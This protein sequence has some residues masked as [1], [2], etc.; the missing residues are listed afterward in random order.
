MPSPGVAGWLFL[1][2]PSPKRHFSVC[3]IF[4]YPSE[5]GPRGLPELGAALCVAISSDCI[6][7]EARGI[8][9]ALQI[10]I[11]GWRGVD[12]V[13]GKDRLILQSRRTTCTLAE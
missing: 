5:I 1:A 13:L 4:N 6:N 9:I 11:M 3:S 10:I 12:V 7:E 2:T 8:S